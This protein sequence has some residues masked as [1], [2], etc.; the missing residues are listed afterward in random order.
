MGNSRDDD[1]GGS[2]GAGCW[3]LLG[4]WFAIEVAGW[5]LMGIFGPGGLPWA[6][7]GTLVVGVVFFMI[8]GTL[9]VLRGHDL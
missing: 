9:R 3:P 8:Y 7:V 4:F 2:R 5:I 1:P 6:L